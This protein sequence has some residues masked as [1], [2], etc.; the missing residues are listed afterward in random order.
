MAI[1]F[2]PLNDLVPCI[3]SDFVPPFVN[4]NHIFPQEYQMDGIGTAWRIRDDLYLR[5]RED[6]TCFE[7]IQGVLETMETSE[8]KLFEE[9]IAFYS[10]SIETLKNNEKTL[11]QELAGTQKLL[12]Q[13]TEIALLYEKH[14][15]LTSRLESER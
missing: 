5:F 7:N 6:I 1:K 13:W 2:Q 11:D 8:E 12:E 14:F 15:G 9:S 10:N 3:E 4:D